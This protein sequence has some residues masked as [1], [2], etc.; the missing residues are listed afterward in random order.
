MFQ[1]IFKKAIQR[2]GLL[3]PSRGEDPDDALYKGHVT[4]KYLRKK[5][6]SRVP[7]S[8]EEGENGEP[9]T[10][11]LEDVEWA[12]EV[13]SNSNV[14]ASNITL[15]LATLIKDS[16]AKNIT[17]LAVGTGPGAYPISTPPPF[18][19][20]EKLVAE[21]IRKPINFTNY[22][23]S[24]GDPTLTVTNTVDLTTIFDTGEAVGT[25]EEMGLFGGQGAE[26]ANGGYISNYKTFTPFSKPSD[27]LMVVTWRIRFTL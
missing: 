17:H 19:S 14:L 13:V 22:V 10:V 12:E 2:V 7:I 1:G 11:Y 24:G 21:L 15:L 26:N 27:R 5:E 9:K 20:N 25:L 3:G 6:G 16:N 8:V 4:I 23:D 18:V